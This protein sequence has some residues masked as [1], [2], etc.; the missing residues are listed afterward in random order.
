MG[1]AEAYALQKEL[2]GEVIDQRPF[3]NACVAIA[4]DLDP[5]AL[6]DACK[7][8]ERARGR[9]TGGVRHGP[10]P[11]DVDVL[12]LG[13]LEYRSERLTVPHPQM[14]TRAF[15]Q[16]PLREVGNFLVL[17]GSEVPGDGAVERVGPPLILP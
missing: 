14:L 15:V 13:E 9:E 3:F 7:A 12:M 10:R 6:L 2:Q 1:Y 16:V 5:E 11:L 17:F 4:T 8:V